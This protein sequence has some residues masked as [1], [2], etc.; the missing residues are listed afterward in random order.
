VNHPEAPSAPP[1]QGAPLADRR[2]P[3]PRRLLG[4][5]GSCIE[6]VHRRRGRLENNAARPPACGGNMMEAF[7]DQE[8]FNLG[9][10]KFLKTVG[11]GSQRE[12]EQAVAK[13]MAAGAIAGT[14]TL[15]ATMTLK[16]DALG[17]ALTFDGEIPLQ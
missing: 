15:A 2:K 12:I 1:P 3:D 8:T 10:R 14:E 9:I 16:I 11:V 13:A 4:Y 17:L 7:M 5:N 6:V